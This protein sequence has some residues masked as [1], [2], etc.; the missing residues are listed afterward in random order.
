MCGRYQLAPEESD[1]ILEIIRQVEGRVK[2]GE[3]YPTNVV[4]VLLEATGELA[5]RP[6]VWG[7]PRFPGKSGNIINARSETVLERPMFRKSMME[8]RCVVPTTG[9]FE[10]GPGADGKKRKYRFRLPGQSALYLAGVWNDYGGERRCVILTSK[11]NASMKEIHDRMPVVLDKETLVS[12][13][14]DTDFA[15]NLLERVS[16]ELAREQSGA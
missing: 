14:E 6:A 4:P 3:I 5:P 12:W 2:T 16:P 8:R 7:F 10:W 15:V 1:E 13:V 9:F 11:A